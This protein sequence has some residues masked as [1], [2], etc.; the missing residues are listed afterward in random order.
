M[1]IN[2][3]LPIIAAN[4]KCKRAQIGAVISKEDRV[5]STGWNGTPSKHSNCC[6]EN[7]TTNRS[8]IHAEANAILFAAKNGTATDGCTIH[9]TMSPCYEC[10]KMIIQSGIV[11]VVFSEVY[12]DDK[13]LEML[14]KSGIELVQIP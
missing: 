7:D 6:E 2:R 10:A 3:L 1:W 5:I 14:R 12:R 13:P 9:I 8:V 11:K 4:S